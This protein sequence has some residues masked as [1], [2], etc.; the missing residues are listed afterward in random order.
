MEHFYLK[1]FGCKVNQY[2][3]QSLR[4]RLL[5]TGLHEA[6]APEDA[7]LIVL[8]FCVVTGRSASRCHRILNSAVRRGKEARLLVAG[9]L[10]PEDRDRIVSDHPDALFISE[11]SPLEWMKAL[12]PKKGE[13]RT[14]NGLEGHTRAF[15]KVQD[16]CDMKCSYCII[17]S[18]RGEERSRPVP[19]VIDEVGRLLKAGFSELVICGIRLGGYRWEGR[20]LDQLLKA[21]L[22]SSDAEFRI[23]LSSL[24]PAEVT[25]P[26]LELIKADKRVARH[27][28]LPLQSGDPSVLKQMKRPY[29]SRLFLDKVKE[30]RVAIEDLAI[31]TDL[32]VG[33]PGEDD[34]AFN[35]SLDLLD[36]A[37]V[38]RVHVFP[39]SVRKG[40]DAA[41]LP[42]VS[43]SVKTLRAKAARDAAV[44]F[45]EAFDKPFVG[46][47]ATVLIETAGYK[48]TG[49]PAGLTSGYQR[50]V[51]TGFPEGDVQRAFVNVMLE[52]YEDGLF[53]GAFIED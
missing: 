34:E 19:D 33:F 39:Y 13:W 29:T 35:A 15:I 31:S 50:T 53:S 24:N 11:D 48:T 12:L 37:R 43:D 20:R 30:A 21:I 7:D 8:N 47:R 14:V 41:N 4:E 36:R 3:G 2:D 42:M 49:L 46:R 1:S 23:R 27:L 25:A 32:I 28:H 51:V 52:Q 45:K 10:T 5:Q 44:S 40:T 6:F 26:V 9:C 18:I 22:D 38:S 16:G 17:P